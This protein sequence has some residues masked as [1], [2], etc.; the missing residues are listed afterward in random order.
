MMESKKELRTLSKN[1]LINIILE[2]VQK[3]EKLENALKIHEN[4]NTPSSQQR[5][6]PET[7]QETDPSKPRF[8][9]API[10]HEGAG[11]RLPKPD[12]VVEH[13]LHNKNLKHIGKYTRTIID[14]TDK[15]LEVIKYIIHQYKTREGKIIES[16]TNLPKNIYGKNVQA[17]VTELKKIG[18]ISDEKIAD[19]L[20]T[21]RPDLSI[22]PATILN[23]ID[24]IA[25]NLEQ[26]RE[27]VKQ[28]I[29]KAPY[30]HAD[31][32]GMRIDGKNGYT[33]LFCNPHNTLYEF[34]PTRARAVAQRVLGEDYDGFLVSDGYVAYD[35][36]K[37]QR[38]WA[39]ILREAKWLA[40]KNPEAELQNKHILQIYQQ[41]NEAKRKPP[42]KRRQ[43]I[44]KLHS[45]AELRHVIEVLKVT[46][47][48][49][50]F[51]GLLQNAAPN[52]FTGVEHPEIPLHNNFGE[53][54][55]RPIVIHRKMMGC[56]RNEKGKRFI[57]NIIS[58]TETWKLQNKNV[59][60]L[61][62]KYA[63]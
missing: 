52:L 33:W 51:A 17:F 6:K 61:L 63:N 41:A 58:M 10:G 30:N 21:L 23:L 43:I 24:G 48:C 4:A 20:K 22:C 12:R 31:E 42:N 19:I 5:F 18:G 9:G 8:P 1:Q 38:C 15:P 13:K 29:Q 46:H 50:K 39:H 59:H 37:Q 35:I 14:F 2:L 47:G 7:K 62:I 60:Q 55:I 56:I 44:K 54:E 16:E 40:K 36:Y 49:K 45:T 26:P 34:D 11:I 57:N 32:T 53:Q 25:Q 28:Q 27:K 3:I